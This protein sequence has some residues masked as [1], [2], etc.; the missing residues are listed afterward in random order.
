MKAYLAEFFGTFIMVLVGTSTIVASSYFSLVNNLVISA[1]F[2]IIVM[3]MIY[4]FRGTSGAHINPAVSLAFFFMGDLS[5]SR[6]LIYLFCQL[7]GGVAASTVVSLLFPL[8]KSFGETTPSIEPLFAFGIELLI[9]AVLMTS[10]VFIAFHKK[11]SN[12][13]APFVGFVVFVLAF[14]FGPYTGASMNP[15]RTFGPAIFSQTTDFLWLYFTAP[16][17]GTSIIGFAYRAFTNPK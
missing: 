6:F 4:V 8:T 12:L 10:I 11:W 13:T 2:G 15:A 17:L 16:F 14:F 9:S 3:T 5:L 7:L 1:S